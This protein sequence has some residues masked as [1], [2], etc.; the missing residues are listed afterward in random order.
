MDSELMKAK[1]TEADRIQA[2]WSQGSPHV[3]RGAEIKRA[4]LLAW[5]G[6]LTSVQ[7]L[8]ISHTSI[9]NIPWEH[10][11]M[12]ASIV[13]GT[14]KFDDVSHDD[15]LGII[16][17]RVKC[18]E[19]EL[20]SVDLSEAE[21]R[22]LVSAMRDR[23]QKVELGCVTL[24]IE[25]IVQYDGQGSCSWLGVSVWTRDGHRLVEWAADKG[26]TVTQDY[27]GGHVMKRKEKEIVT[28]CSQEARTLL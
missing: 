2:A 27:L 16:L 24:D 6:F 9:R 15:H 25:K 19:L 14:V 7:C 28:K 20:S 22:A 4:A 5:E 21:T 12:L 26:W 3:P 13:T 8:L 1:R 10:M 11:E 18:P 23:V 17:D